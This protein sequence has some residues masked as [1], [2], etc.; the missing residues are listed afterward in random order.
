MSGAS[1]KVYVLSKESWTARFVDRQV[2]ESTE[3]WPCPEGRKSS[4]VLSLVL[5]TLGRP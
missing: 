2:S 1:L 5:F 4:A 3:S